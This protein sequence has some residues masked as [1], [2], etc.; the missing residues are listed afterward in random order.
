MFFGSSSISVA[1]LVTR[2]MY[3]DLVWRILVSWD[4]N[5][6]SPADA[7]FSHCRFVWMSQTDVSVVLLDP[8]INGTA[9]LPNVNL[10]TFAGY[11]EHDW[12]FPSQVVI[13]LT[14]IIME[15]YHCCQLHTK[16]CPTFFSLG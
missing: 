5:T 6:M 9:S 13:K 14:A 7:V 11:A 1:F 3:L 4:L 10:A 15:A 16:F 8:G 12:S 2:S